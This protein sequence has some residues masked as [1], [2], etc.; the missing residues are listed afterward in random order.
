M[1][2]PTRLSSCKSRTATVGSHGDK[3]VLKYGK[4]E[5]FVI[6]AN[7]IRSGWYR[8]LALGMADWITCFQAPIALKTIKLMPSSSW[9]V[10][11]DWLA[12]YINFCKFTIRFSVP[13][14]RDSMSA[15]S[16]SWLEKIRLAWWLRRWSDSCGT[17]IKS[18]L[19]VKLAGN[20]S[21]KCVRK[22]SGPG[23]VVSISRWFCD[24]S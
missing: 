18:R 19:T 8:N 22:T 2:M 5:Y 23:S 1:G 6:S 21:F 4:S 10:M 7:A 13:I 12:W 11:R 24:C 20:W 16:T 3:F 9:N 15:V 14:K 17:V